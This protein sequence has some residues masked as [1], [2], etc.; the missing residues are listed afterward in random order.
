VNKYKFLT[1]AMVDRMDK[2][3]PGCHVIFCFFF[4]VL[5]KLTTKFLKREMV[6][7]ASQVSE[8]SH[9]KKEKVRWHIRN[10]KNN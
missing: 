1:F 10:K 4:F 8:M 2:S 7:Y 6:P 3:A 9:G 5:E